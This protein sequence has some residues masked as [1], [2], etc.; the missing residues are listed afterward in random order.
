MEKEIA[1]EEELE[2][3]ISNYKGDIQIFKLKSLAM[4]NFEKAQEPYAMA[5]EL[6]YQRKK[7]G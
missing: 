4:K 5:V 3:Y 1:K 6:A 7:V 2:K